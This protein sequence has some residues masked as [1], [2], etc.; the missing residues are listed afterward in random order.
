LRVLIVDDCEDTTSSMAWLVRAWGFVAEEANCGRDAL[1]LAAAV[2]P[3]VVLLDLMMP[4]MDGYAVARGL[5]KLPGREDV[6]VVLLSGCN[7]TN[8]GSSVPWEAFCLH[9][10]KPLDLEQLRQFL[11][12]SEKEMCCHDPET[13]STTV[14]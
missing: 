6:L 3:D 14:D 1:R 12:R 7:D 2:R 9:M 11:I 10:R 4:G 5:R 8:E 13:T